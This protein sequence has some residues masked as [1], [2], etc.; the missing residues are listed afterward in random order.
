MSKR[1][2]K[3]KAVAFDAL[4]QSNLNAA[5]IDVHA[6]ELFVAVPKGRDEESV[7]SFPSFTSD[8]HRL[9]DWLQSCDIGT[10]AMESTGISGFLSTRFLRSVVSMC[11]W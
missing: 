10:V 11:A 6:E 4:E 9:A 1:K 8:L 3:R 2:G 5:G 7:R